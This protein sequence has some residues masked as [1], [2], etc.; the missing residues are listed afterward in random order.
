MK[1]GLIGLPNSG[2]TT[3]F[4][5][6][7]GL[8]IDIS[9]FH[10]KEPNLAMVEILDERITKLAELY[11]PDKITYA[12]MEVIDF[13]ADDTA[14]REER[15]NFPQIKILDALTIVIRNFKDNILDETYGKAD[16]IRDLKEIEAEMLLSDMIITEKRLDKVKQNM[17]RNVPDAA[18]EEKTLQK[19]L[20]ALQEEKPIREL[21][22]TPEEDKMIRGFQLLSNKP[23]MVLI[24]SDENSYGKN[25]AVISELKDKGY[26]V[27]EIA[28]KY[29]M[30]LSTLDEED[31][32]IFRAEM[33]I[34]DSAKDRIIALAYRILGYISFFTAG[35]QEVRA[36]TI[37]KGQ[38]AQEAAGKI[39]SDMEKGFIRA[40]CFSYDDLIEYGNEKTIKEKG[41]FRLEGKTYQV[42]DA[43]ILVIRFNK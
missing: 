14:E 4:N 6:L 39:H 25:A 42:K 32:L 22:L 40:E 12:T 26:F 38:N 34:N 10:K 43:D 24:N 2:K 3:V 21:D 36:W 35:K 27:D 7:T 33:N 15:F 11:V 20:T 31:A 41:K 16:I 18:A 13:A 5:A 28:G 29:E 9:Y 37:V 23:V 19:I 30:E 1:L 17:K 8:N